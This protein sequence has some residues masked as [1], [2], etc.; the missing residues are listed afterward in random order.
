VLVSI[1][2]F[3]LY[4]ECTMLATNGYSVK[5]N[6]KGAQGPGVNRTGPEIEPA[7]TDA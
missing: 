2:T 5:Y 1:I 7:P 6:G 3:P 4:P